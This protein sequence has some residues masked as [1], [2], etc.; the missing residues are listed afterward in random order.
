MKP[1]LFKD[2]KTPIGN[3]RVR[4]FLN[5]SQLHSAFE[6]YAKSKSPEKTSCEV[7]IEFNDGSRDILYFERVYDYMEYRDYDGEVWQA[8]YYR[9]KWCHPLIDHQSTSIRRL[10]KE[11]SDEARV[12]SIE[13]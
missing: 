13:M 1:T 11:Y 2:S 5:Q 6:T 10:V 12:I 9:K 7:V 4:R 8:W 3:R